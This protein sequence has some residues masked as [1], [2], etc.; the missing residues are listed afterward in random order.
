MENNTNK[1][2]V[3]R[4]VKAINDHDVDGII[5]LMSE[6][7]TF[8]DGM[9]NKSV[10]KNGMKEGWKGY[11]ELFPDYQIEI[12]VIVENASVIG[13]FGYAS[14]TYK[15]LTNKSNSNFWRIP[16]AWKAIVENNKI[17]HWQVYCD[18]S[19]LFK[20]IDKNK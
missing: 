13:L 5:N 20:I 18:Y 9:D 3:I 17:K 14:A 10:G 15:N 4:F 16:A 1:T 2:V 11:Y 6:D 8:I 7:H 12:S 19:N